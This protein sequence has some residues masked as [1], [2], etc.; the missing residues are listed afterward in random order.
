MVRLACVDDLD[1]IYALCVEAHIKLP[2]SHIAID[3][4]ELRMIISALVKLG[5]VWVTND[6]TGLLM[7]AV[8]PV[9]FNS[10]KSMSNDMVFYTKKGSGVQLIRA[11]TKWA[12]NHVDMV[13]ISISSGANVERTE[14]F[15]QHMGF[16]RVGG[17][18]ILGV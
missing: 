5:T 13:G 2:Y 18:F 16:N 14:K 4:A 3:E 7:A 17:T 12:I 15:Y 1:E 9:W 10:K 8:S 11:Y 6:L